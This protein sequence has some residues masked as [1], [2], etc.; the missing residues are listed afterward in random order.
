M[1]FTLLA[2][3]TSDGERVVML[4]L[5]LKNAEISLTETPQN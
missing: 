5:V 1:N 3:I 2:K 4:V